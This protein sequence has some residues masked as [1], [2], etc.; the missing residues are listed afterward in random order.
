MESSLTFSE[1]IFNLI[2]L[3]LLSTS[4]LS[5]I[6]RS[7]SLSTLTSIVQ[8]LQCD[9]PYRFYFSQY[10]VTV[11]WRVAQLAL[12]LLSSVNSRAYLHV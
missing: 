12:C 10:L 11:D 2:T 6:R 8:H 5:A 4:G 3:L 7:V 9:S 1:Y